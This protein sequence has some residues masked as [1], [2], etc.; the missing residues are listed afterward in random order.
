MTLKF[1]AP[2]LAAALLVT[3]CQN[4][5][6]PRE[7]VGTAGGA[8]VGGLLGSQIGSGTGQLAAT[9]AGTLL[10]AFIGRDIG[11]RLDDVDRLKAQ[12]TAQRTFETA[13]T[14]STGT[15]RNPDS[16][17]YGTVTPT[18]TYQQG[19]QPCRDFTQTVYVG[20]QEVQ[21]T[22]TACRQADGTWRV[23]N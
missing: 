16:G 8:A 23:V 1:I 22:G 19:S 10:G 18:A 7:A 9:A 5:P 4:G 12:Q 6:G 21:E 15:W 20:G 14:G 17:H 13:P 2:A 11:A 3:A